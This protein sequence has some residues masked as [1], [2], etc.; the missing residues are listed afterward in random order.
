[1]LQ[2][3]KKILCLSLL[4]AIFAGCLFYSGKNAVLEAASVSELQ[5][6]IDSKNDQI[7]NLEAEIKK[8]ESELL[9]VGSN[10]K[11]LQNAINELNLAKKKLETDIALTEKNIEKANLTI[12]NLGSEIN[13]K[14]SDITNTESYLKSTL[15]NIQMT[16]E[17]SAIENL[18]VYKDLGTFSAY[19][20]S[21]T[22]LGTTLRSRLHE[23][24]NL[25]EELSTKQGEEV[26]KK[27]ELS[28]FKKELT[29]KKQSVL[30]TAKQ[31]NVLLSQTKSQEALYQQTVA[32]K[33]KQKEQF[34]KELFQ[35]ESELKIAI[36]PNKL[37]TAKKGVLAWPL[38]NVYITQYFGSTVAAQRLYTSGS[39][40]GI[41]LRATDG[42]KVF[43]SESGTV[44]ATGNTDLKSGC[45]SYGK[46][47][48]IKHSNGLSTLYGHL[49]SIEVSPGDSVKIGQEIALSGRTGYVTGP[50][51][52]L[53]VLA[54]EG[55][56][57]MVIPNEKTKN[58]QGV[59]IPI[60]DPKAYLDP[61]V[62]L[63]SI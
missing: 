26:E 52:H 31:K 46:W 22:R 35:Y 51:L 54:T 44:W 58:C 5:D 23:L 4:F 32:E 50:H 21:V 10:K 17:Q 15:R 33:K 29:G 56:R 42:T 6:K 62:Y 1:M 34:E 47:V 8:L 18:L 63:G 53:T 20:E 19:I 2:K 25:Q 37:P 27:E 41:D 57:V 60:A 40:N 38:Q 9:V 43:A 12:Q 13:Q 55:T 16:D 14:E 30:E 48:L 61:M 49:S 39:H 59:T 7:K 45:Y 36:D 11:T 28:T 24:Q 3:N